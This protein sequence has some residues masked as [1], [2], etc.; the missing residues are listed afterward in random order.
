VSTQL[1]TAREKQQLADLVNTMIS[2]GLTYKQEKGPDG[3]YHYILDPCLEE[4]CRFPGLAQ[5]KQLTYN[6]KQLIAR[7]VEVEKMRR[8]ERMLS[9]QNSPSPVLVLPGAFGLPEGRRRS[10]Q[11][12]GKS[13]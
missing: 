12:R 11:V 6:A 2:Y 4:V 5:S 9:G 8:A 1:Y 10:V 3:Q 7:E 13:V